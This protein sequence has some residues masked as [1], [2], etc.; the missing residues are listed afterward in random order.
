MGYGMNNEQNYS[1]V[2]VMN[3]DDIRGGGC[4]DNPEDCTNL[5]NEITVTSVTI[6]DG[7]MFAETKNIE[8]NYKTTNDGQ[9]ANQPVNKKLAAAFTQTV[10]EAAII[11]DITS[12]T[13]SST[14]NGRDD[15]GSTS[16]NHPNGVALD[17]SKING[18]SVLFHGA[19]SPQV[20]A[21][22]NSFENRERAREN[23]GPSKMLKLGSAYGSDYLR[24]DHEDHIHFSITSCRKCARYS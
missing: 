11:S 21:L 14:S 7:Q 3:K 15:T 13:I 24:R 17:I 2:N 6:E 22:Q 10:V 20:Q 23:F 1:G 8:I 19:D 16:P 5:P 4:E 18:T 9:S 12:L